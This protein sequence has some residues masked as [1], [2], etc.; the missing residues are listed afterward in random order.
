MNGKLITGLNAKVKT[1]N[2]G[3]DFF[4]VAFYKEVID[5]YELFWTKNKLS[6]FKDGVPYRTDEPRR[7]PRSDGFNFGRQQR[8]TRA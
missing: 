5:A 2:N 7:R 3:D 4:S 1:S 6:H 8:R